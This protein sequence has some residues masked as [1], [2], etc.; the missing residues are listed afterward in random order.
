MVWPPIRKIFKD[1]IPILLSFNYT[2]SMQ[3]FLAER[4]KKLNS[5]L[6]VRLN[7]ALYNRLEDAKNHVFFQHE[8]ADGY[9]TLAKKGR[10]GRFFQ[11]H[12]K[13]EELADHLSEFMG[14]DVYFSQN[15]FYRPQRRIENIRQLR[16]LYI[17]IDC[18]N[19]GLKPEWV[20]GKLELEQFKQTIPEPNLVIFS[21]RGLVLIWLIEPVSH[22]ALP[23]W[24]AIQNYFLDNLKELG[25]D[26]K[27]IDAAR[28]F[29]VAGSTN[30]KNKA[31]VQVEYRHDYKYALRDIQYEYLPELT[32]RPKGEKPKTGRKKRIIHLFNIY[33]LN[34][35]RVLDITKLIELRNYDVT[36]Y[37][38]VICFLYRYWTL[39]L[40]NDAEDALQQTFELNSTFTHPLPQRELKRA[41][42]SAEKAFEAKNNK[43][44]DELAKKQGYPG[45][46]Y[47]ISN[48][49]LI[50]WLDIT[51]DEM[52]HMTTIIN[53]AEKRRRDRV[54]KEKERREAG[55]RTDAERRA[56]D[57]RA[58]DEKADILKSLI[59]EHGALSVRKLSA[60]S[61]IPKSTVQRLKKEYN[62]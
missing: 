41:T 10:N 8:G 3:S 45:A 56:D 12:Y 23:L 18:Q 39:C 28:V 57:K 49:K 9:I 4:M 62:F 24:N 55:I 60:M 51:Q 46:G 27:A 40:C 22:H 44:A 29:R 58:M 47:N 59:A 11:R 19:L 53:P 14:E 61:N 2:I 38:E 17:D 34:H 52:E 54:K 30:S 5:N 50:K 36:G 37:R 13:P 33:S 16:S 32:P 35:A 6:A 42:R 7:D 31:T 21:G 48:A 1:C 43:V 25:G 26:S 20:L 15:T